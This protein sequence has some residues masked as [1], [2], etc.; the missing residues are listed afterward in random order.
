[1]KG[2]DQSGACL[3]AQA[4]GRRPARS[5]QLLG[6]LDRGADFADA[7]EDFR[8]QVGGGRVAAAV[9]GHEPLHR[10]LKA[11][12]AQAGAAFVQMLADLR[13]VDVANLA[14]QIAV[15]PFQYLGTRRL[16]WLS[17]AHRPSSPGREASE[18]VCA[19]PRSDA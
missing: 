17:A 14:V 7:D 18:P 16:V 6:E 3:P 19:K 13:S 15:D 12:L 10:F 9:L 11:V 4:G 8:A 2:W 1:M 5:G